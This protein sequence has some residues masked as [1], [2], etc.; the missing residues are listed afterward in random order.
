MNKMLPLLLMPALWIATSCSKPAPA[1]VD[2]KQFLADT[3][4]KLNTLNVESQRADW[5]H[6]NFITDDTEALSA[7]AD[8]RSIDEGVRSAKAA[9]QFDKA[10]LP[11]DQTR[12]LKLLKIGLVLATPSDP[13]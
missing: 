7:K 3:E 12:K 5:V 8:Q 13:K 1:G 6:E 10:T 2:A 4:A 11:E 9:T